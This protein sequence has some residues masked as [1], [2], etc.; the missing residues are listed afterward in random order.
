LQDLVTDFDAS[1]AAW[2]TP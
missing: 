2:Q 1:I